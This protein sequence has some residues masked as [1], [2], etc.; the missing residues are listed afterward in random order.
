MMYFDLNDHDTRVLLR[1]KIISSIS[2]GLDWSA[3]ISRY[4][5]DPLD[6]PNDNAPRRPIAYEEYE[7]LVDRVSAAAIV[8][9]ETHV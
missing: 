7:L 4:L 1:R 9:I 2:R 8:A 6:Q 5:P 3:V